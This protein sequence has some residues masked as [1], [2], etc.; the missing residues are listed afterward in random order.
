VALKTSFNYQPPKRSKTN[1]NAAFT[2]EGVPLYSEKRT[3]GTAKAEALLKALV[4][5][6]PTPPKRFNGSFSR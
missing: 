3:A 4:K 2:E 6:M 1:R 5:P